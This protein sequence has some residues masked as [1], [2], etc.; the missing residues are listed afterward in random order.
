MNTKK[1]IFLENQRKIKDIYDQNYEILR[2]FKYNV[3][4]SEN[5]KIKWEISQLITD[6]QIRRIDPN[7]DIVAVY[8][9]SE[10]GDDNNYYTDDIYSLFKF[11]LKNYIYVDYVNE[12]NVMY[13]EDVKK[14]NDIES[15]TNDI[16][17]GHVIQLK[18]SKNLEKF[19]EDLLVKIIDL[20][21][22][23]N[24]LLV[25]QLVNSILE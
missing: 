4:V 23:G 15:E 3:Q 1:T 14:D 10:Y 21:I 24:L 19:E 6:F 20:M 2:S 5:F 11:C 17:I 18:I 25:E 9:W 7:L 12:V 16:Y 13:I 8:N 22:S